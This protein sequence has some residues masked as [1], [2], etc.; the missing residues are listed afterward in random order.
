KG[1]RRAWRP[2]QRALLLHYP[3]RGRLRAAIG[4]VAGAERRLELLL[5][6]ARLR[7]LLRDVGATDQ[8]ATDAHLADRRPAGEPSRLLADRW[9]GEDVD[10]G[11]RSA[12][13]AQRLERTQ[14]VPA[15]DPLRRA[16]HEQGH[17]L[18]RDHLLDLLPQLHHRL[19]VVLILSS[20]IVPSARGSAS[21]S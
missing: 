15:H 9:V 16:L 21:A 11:D 6:L 3:K 19:P 18:L 10:G 17:R 20:W 7:Q 13:P 8:L 12:R 2:P 14:R 1:V 5:E 4:P